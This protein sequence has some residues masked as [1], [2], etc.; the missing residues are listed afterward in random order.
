MASPAARHWSLDSG[1]AHLNHGS[2]GAAPTRVLEEQR[3]WRDLLESNPDAFMLVDYQP[4]L[5]AA[6]T[7]LA[8]FVGADPAGIGFLDNVTSGVNSVLRSLEPTLGPGDEILITDHT[9]NACRNAVLVTAERSGATVKTAAV[10]FP[11]AS[12]AQVTSAILDAITPRT[13]LL[14]IDVVTSPTGLVFPVSEIIAAAEPEVQVLLDAAHAPGMIDFD[15]SALGA[16]YVTAN[17]HKWMCS[18]KGAAFLA[19]TEDRRDIIYPSVISHGYN[20]GWPSTGGHIHR[21]FDWTGT[22]D[23]SAWLSVPTAIETLA[24]INPDGWDGVLRDNHELCLAG[25]D[26]ILSVLGIDAPAPNEMIGSIAAVPIPDPADQAEHIFDPLMMTLHE[27][28][29]IEVPVFAWP[30]SP[31]RLLRISAQQYNSLDEYHQL[32]E[33]LSAELAL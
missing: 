17:C 14:V 29:R 33:A 31:N 23:P 30:E 20:D 2:F 6:R 1:I 8:A 5:D 28:W 26:V 15:I 27:K 7:E 22:R 19:V 4:A 24:D 18:P 11:I 3:R 25:R 10:P 13:R 32:A 21:Q 12:A 9:Y 16:S